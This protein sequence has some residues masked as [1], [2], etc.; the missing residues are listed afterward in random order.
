MEEQT[1]YLVSGPLQKN[2]TRE[3]NSGLG[4][5]EISQGKKE[6]K[7][8]FPNFYFPADCFLAAKL[9]G[10]IMHMMAVS[11][12]ERVKHGGITARMETICFFQCE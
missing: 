3:W 9:E 11:K 4:G 5:N 1:R 7:G 2:G 10:N 8:A 6:T 12:W